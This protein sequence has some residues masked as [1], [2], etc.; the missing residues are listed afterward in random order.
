MAGKATSKKPAAKAAAK[1][2]DEANRGVLFQNDKDGNENRPD[3]TGSIKI[4]VED[5]EADADG[6]ITVR[7]AAWQKESGK[8]GT[9]L[10][11]SASVAQK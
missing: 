6:L 2:Y 9:Y 3:M 1:D 11:L 7:L 10:S 5:F 8:V 4:K